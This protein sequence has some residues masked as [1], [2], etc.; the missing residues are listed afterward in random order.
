MVLSMTG[1]GSDIINTKD[2]NIDIEVKSLNSKYFDFNYR[3]NYD[4]KLL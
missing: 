3:S 4:N 1:Y 2:I